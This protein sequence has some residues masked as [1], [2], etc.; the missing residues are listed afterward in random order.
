MSQPSPLLQGAAAV[1]PVRRQ[2]KCACRMVQRCILGWSC[3]QG[4]LAPHLRR[5]LW[6]HLLPCSLHGWLGP[7]DALRSGRLRSLLCGALSGLPW[8]WGH[9]LLPQAPWSLA[10]VGCCGRME[11][12]PVPLAPAIHLCNAR[13]PAGHLAVQVAYLMKPMS[14]LFAPGLVLKVLWLLLRGAHGGG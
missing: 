2:W 8:L 7:A 1:L 4:P 12:K 6:F 14:A 9:L 5:S 10:G 11:G 13:L 3:P